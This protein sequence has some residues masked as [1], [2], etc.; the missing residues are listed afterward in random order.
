MMWCFSRMLY[1]KKKK[2]ERFKKTAY[3]LKGNRVH[4]Q[5][6]VWASRFV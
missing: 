2:K 6:E 1:I 4:C 5:T 3:L